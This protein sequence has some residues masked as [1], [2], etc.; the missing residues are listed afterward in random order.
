MFALPGSVRQAFEHFVDPVEVVHCGLHGT[1]FKDFLARQQADGTQ[2]LG[3][4]GQ[5]IFHDGVLLCEESQIVLV[6]EA[7]HTGP[8]DPKKS[9]TQCHA[10]HLGRTQ[11]NLVSADIDLNALARQV[12]ILT[13]DPENP[14]SFL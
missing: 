2:N 4:E 7:E 6:D 1:F 5:H 10:D 12:N 3:E 9:A 8:R 13:F 14:F 11:E